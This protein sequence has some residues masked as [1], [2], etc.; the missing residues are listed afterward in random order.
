[1]RLTKKEKE[2]LFELLD[3]ATDRCPTL[4]IDEITQ[5]ANQEYLWNVFKKL[6]LELR[7]Y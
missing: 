6:R 2:V 5:G 7:G 3:C 4:R 1:M